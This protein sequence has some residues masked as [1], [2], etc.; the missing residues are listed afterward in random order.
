[1]NYLLLKFLAGFYLFLSPFSPEASS[2]ISNQEFE[3]QHLI[4]NDS[5]FILWQ[6]EVES[7]LEITDSNREL[8]IDVY[9]KYINAEHFNNFR[10][11]DLSY[12]RIS[13]HLLISFTTTAIIYPFNFFL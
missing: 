9:G 13:Q 11:I 7:L 3:Q 10:L 12:L 5:E 4:T 6:F 2:T 1:M 8:F